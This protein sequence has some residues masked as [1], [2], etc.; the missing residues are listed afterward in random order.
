MRIR[1]NPSLIAISLLFCTS[2]PH[3]VD[4]AAAPEASPMPERIE[5]RLKVSRYMEQHCSPTTYSGWE[6]FETIR[7]SYTVTDKRTGRE[8]KGLVVMLNP[9]ASKLSSWIGEACKAVRPDLEAERCSEYLLDRVVTQ[10]GGQFVVAGVVY[11][12]IIPKDGVYEAYAFRDGVTVSIKDIRHRRTVP[13]TDYEL[14]AA[15]DATPLGTI[16]NPAYSRI[17]GTSRGEYLWA[18]TGADVSGMKWPALV[19]SSYQKAW[20]DDRNHLI[21]EWLRNNPPEDR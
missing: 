21:E 7:C 15:L 2:I 6:G 12:D 19:R 9:S 10:S 5:K 20:R 4:A 3:S 17:V 13:L 16:S 11:E 18:N 14:E 1:A 8:K